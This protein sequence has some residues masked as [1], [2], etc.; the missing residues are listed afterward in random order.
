MC[1]LTHVFADGAPAPAGFNEAWLVVL[2]KGSEAADTRGECARAADSLRPLLLKNTDS[3]I[4][5]GTLARGMR[6]IL[7]KAVHPTQRG[8]VADRDLVRNIAELDTYARALHTTVMS[9]DL[10]VLLLC[11]MAAAFPS[12]S[13]RWLRA[14]LERLGVPRPAIRVIEALNSGML[15]LLNM[16][17]WS[18]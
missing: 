5:A 1:M 2:P 10:L 17:G 6:P 18:P 15:L 8:F 13:R 3:K 12:V 7:S 9:D 16:G 14:V 11:D 4:V